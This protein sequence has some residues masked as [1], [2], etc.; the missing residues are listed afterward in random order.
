MYVA[1]DSPGPMRYAR[2]GERVRLPSAEPP[3]IVVDHSVHRVLVVRWPGRLFRVA[4]VPPADDEERAALA[5]A[6]A[7]LRADAGYTRA[8][9]V[10]ILAELPAATLFG[11]HG[12]AVVELLAYAD[13]LA[14]PA[15]RDLA[16]A[17]HPEADRA[18]DRAWRRWLAGQPNGAAYRDGDQAGVLAVPGAGSV[19][20]PIGH[21]LTV[22][23]RRVAET[24][25]RVAGPA[26]FEVDEDGDEVLLDPWSTAAAALLDAALALGA[27]ELVDA[28]DA[29]RLASAWRTVGGR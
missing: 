26:A 2:V 10:D 4:S 15:A 13:Q 5:R 11:P 14:E 24:A 16:A 28:A 9:A 3:W 18:Y 1:D 12:A 19:G 8:I 25:R 20:S 27:P 17:R 6:A 23:W 7:N 21:G 29:D 22:L